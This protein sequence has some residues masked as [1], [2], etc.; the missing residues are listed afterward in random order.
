MTWRIEENPP[1]MESKYEVEW[2]NEYFWNDTIIINY[3][4]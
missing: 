4:K 1:A 3:V 2:K